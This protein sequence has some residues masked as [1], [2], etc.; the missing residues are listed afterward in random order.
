MVTRKNRAQDSNEGSQDPQVTSGTEAE[1]ETSADGE[2]EVGDGDDGDDSSD[3]SEP[4]PVAPPLTGAER[5]ALAESKIE[6]L[7]AAMHDMAS[8][9]FSHA[10]AKDAWLKKHFGG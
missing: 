4:T 5:L 9:A 6:Q 8:H 1:E 2:P 3:T 7:I 10:E